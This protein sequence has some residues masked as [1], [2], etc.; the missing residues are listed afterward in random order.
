MIKYII[1]YLDKIAEKVKVIEEDNKKVNNTNILFAYRGEPKNYRE[2]KLMPSLFRN[3]SFVAKERYLFELLGDYNIIGTEKK[4]YIE[5]S[6]EAQHYISISRNLDITFSILLA[7]YFACKSEKKEDGVLYVFGF[8]KYFSPHSSYIEEVY[9]NILEDGSLIYDKNF[10]VITHSRYNERILAQNGGFIFFPG[11]KYCPIPKLYYQEVKIE[12]N[13]KK[14][15]L[16]ELQDYF[17]IN[18][19]K[20]FPEKSNDAKYVKDLFTENAIQDEKNI[21]SVINEI[22]FFFDRIDYETEMLRIDRTLTD[23]KF[24]RILRKEKEDL[25]FF[26]NQ[27]KEDEIKKQENEDSSKIEQE[28]SF[29]I[30]EVEKRFAVLRR[31]K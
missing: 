3:P 2:T 15:I 14:D 12:K 24:L 13:H 26:L 5:K 18:E 29:Y 8:P 22:D 31:S 4:R 28:Y 17:D 16:N 19:S 10:R 25:V 20:I 6:I 11:K 1:D 23:E 21:L 30:E 9:K 27:L 7:L